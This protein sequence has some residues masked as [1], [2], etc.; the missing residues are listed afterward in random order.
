[1]ASRD[2]EWQE[3]GTTAGG[4][5]VQARY[6]GNHLQMKV[7]FEVP[8][9]KPKRIVLQDDGAQPAPKA[10]D[11][12]CNDTPRKGA[13]VFYHVQD[14]RLVPRKRLSSPFRYVCLCWPATAADVEKREPG[15]TLWHYYRK[16]KTQP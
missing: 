9:A 4:F 13:P 11:F 15:Q 6:V 2:T 14:A 7:D 8:F 10:D 12:L 3:T 1:M 5:P 16:R